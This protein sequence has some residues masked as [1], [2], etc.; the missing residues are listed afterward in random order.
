[1]SDN[2]SILV[3]I[4]SQPQKGQE[5]LGDK[6]MS[7]FYAFRN[8]LIK[9]GLE[10]PEGGD[11]LLLFVYDHPYS[12]FSSV[13]ECLHAVKE[14]FD[15]KDS[16][17]P[18]PI[19]IIFHLEKKGDLPAP[20][21]EPS[22]NLWDLLKEETPYITRSLKVRWDALMKEKSLPGHNF[23]SEEMGLFRVDFLDKFLIRKEK[24]FP[25]RDLVRQGELKECFY[26]GMTNHK[27]SNCPSKLLTMET[28]GL[29]EIGYHP[30]VRLSEIFK[31]TFSEQE[32]YLNILAAG[33]TLSQLRKDINLQIFV[34][35]FDVFRIYQPRFLWNFSFASLSKWEQLGKPEMIS[36]DSQNLHLGFDCLRVGQYEQAEEFFVDESRRP[37]GKQFCATIGRAFMALETERYSD[38]GHYLESANTMATTDNERIYISLLLS[39]Y[40][41]IEGDLWKAEQTVDNL[42]TVKRDCAD[43]LYR[44]VQLLVKSGVDEKALR[45]LRALVTEDKEIFMASLMDPL[46]LPLTGPIED[47]LSS[48]AQAQRQEAEE[49]LVQARIQTEDL[50]SWVAEDDPQVEIY[51]ND[52]VDLEGKFERQSY[53][54]TIDVAERSKAMV[55]ACFRFQEV[56]LDELYKDFKKA[57]S[58]CNGYFDFWKNYTYQNFF[59]EFY[60]KLIAIEKKLKEVQPLTEKNQGG[61]FYRKAVEL[62][63][64][65]V[66][67]LN[68]VRSTITRMN[69]VKIFFDGIK[70]FGKKLLIAEAFS[71]ILLVFLVPALSM[72]LTDSIAEEL[73]GLIK[74]PL[75]QK[76]VLFIVTLLI[77]PMVALAQTLWK[78]MET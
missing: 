78:I 24:L 64:E 57:L 30:I 38:L 60:I 68:G 15:W 51:T 3:A 14:E 8:L 36:V 32:K 54:D 77:A 18:V 44:Q 52:L 67:D 22:S 49:F 43:G 13:F 41:E 53:F 69:W 42:F 73:I 28:Q 39:R 31:E 56:R 47:M 9:T 35:Y 6:W 25:H 12:A 29:P 11:H 74:N 65:I 61:R 34:A 76:Q 46:L 20:L 63:E 59:K 5:F 21:R 72:L 33:A 10:D 70:L 40:Y 50:W 26:C 16:F 7:F 62:L 37:R 4:R 19:Q 17:G 48:R 55:S 1:M 45:Q 2:Y 23:E 66:S 75:F 71:L 27:P 58:R